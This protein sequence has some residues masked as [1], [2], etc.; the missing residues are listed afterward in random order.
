VIRAVLFDFGGTLY[1]YASLEPG[2]RESL[3]ALAEWAG[4][5]AEAA[6]I[7]RAYRESMRRVFHRYLPRS[8]YLHRDLFRDAAAGMLED[9][10]VP[11]LE[12]HLDRY[13]AMQWE[14]HQRD[15]VLREG[16]LD[17][18]RAI[19]DRGLRV[20]LV[21]NIDEDQLAHLLEIAG[22]ADELDFHIS[23]ERARSC[24]PHGAIFGAAVRL[25]DCAAEEALFVGDTVRQDVAG[26]NQ[27][28]LVSVLLWHRPDREPPEEG[29][30]PRH[31]IA[32]IPQVLE[33]ISDER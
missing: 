4:V 22:I 14:R 8:F 24:K 23:S 7:R 15:F 3:A 31:V 16:V 33:L 9:L 29:P 32:T 25:A 10:G 11:A 20:G 17:T 6:E 2:D 18:L 21:S 1:D 28:G 5:E 13:R 19:R 30:R 26:A 27:A 12:E